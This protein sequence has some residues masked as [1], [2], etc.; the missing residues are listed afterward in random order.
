MGVAILREAIPG[1]PERRDV[2]DVGGASFTSSLS[3]CDKVFAGFF[4]FFAFFAI[5]Y[6]R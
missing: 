6:Y 1:E 3:S 5:L 4:V 2:M